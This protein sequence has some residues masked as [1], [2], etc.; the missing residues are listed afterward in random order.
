MFDHR[1]RIAL[2]EQRYEKVSRVAKRRGIPVAAVIRD[3]IDQLPADR[4]G[5]AAAI[6]AI[7][8]AEPMPVPADPADLRRELDISRDRI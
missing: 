5:H 4:E 2:D 8:E 1:V 3:A 6:A 7:L